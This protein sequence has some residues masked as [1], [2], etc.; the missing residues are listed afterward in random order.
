M[1]FEPYYEDMDTW[2]Y[3][4]YCTFS[5]IFHW[6]SRYAVDFNSYMS[7]LRV[8]SFWKLGGIRKK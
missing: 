7:E 6:L 5:F 1:V 3:L 4:S 2:L 8:W